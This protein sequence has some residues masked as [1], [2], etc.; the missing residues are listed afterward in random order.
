MKTIT[1]YEANDGTRFDSVAKVMQYEEFAERCKA[2][3]DM[4]P[5]VPHNN[6]DRIQLNRSVME[7]AWSEFIKLY[8]EKCNEKADASYHFASIIGR[9]VDDCGVPCLKKLYYKFHCIN[10]DL[11]RM[12][13]QPYFAQYGGKEA[14]Q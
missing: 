2:V 6:A 5:A 14:T 8:N 12:Y 9:I 1:L 13:S 7:A 3:S 4:L 11:A 10:R